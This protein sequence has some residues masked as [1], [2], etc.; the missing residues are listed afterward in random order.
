MY[1]PQVNSVQEKKNS[2]NKN[3]DNNGD[4]IRQL[5]RGEVLAI[6]MPIG[7]MCCTRFRFFLFC[8]TGNKVF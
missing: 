7:V 2:K 4:E 8:S 1:N 5:H 6:A 3:I